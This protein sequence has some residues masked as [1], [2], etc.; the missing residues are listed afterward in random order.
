LSPVLSPVL[1]LW[2]F[3]LV[4]CGVKLAC[5]LPDRYRYIYF[6]L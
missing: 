5:A 1:F 3:S 4:P 6:N 2:N